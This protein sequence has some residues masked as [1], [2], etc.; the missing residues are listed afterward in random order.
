M[1]RH[2]VPKLGVESKKKEKRD[3]MI[4]QQGRMPV[5]AVDIGRPDK[6][7]GHQSNKD[8]IVAALKNPPKHVITI[9]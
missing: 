2:W 5:P 3:G 1:F 6:L 8:I 7:T 4:E 9:S